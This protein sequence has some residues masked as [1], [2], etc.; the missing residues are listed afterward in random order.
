MKNLVRKLIARF[1]NRMLRS[2]KVWSMVD[3][4]RTILPR[5]SANP[6]LFIQ[7]FRTNTKNGN[8]VWYSFG[9]LS[10]WRYDTLFTKEPETI[11]WIESFS[12]R[13]VFWD[14]GANVGVYSIYA[15]AVRGCRVVAFE[16]SPTN[17]YVLTK[18]IQLNGLSERIVA[19]P[20]ALSDVTGMG[21]LNMHTLE[22]GGALSHF[23]ER[24][25]GISLD[26]H[27]HFPVEHRL[28]AAGF[29]ADALRA[30]MALE[31]PHHIK[32]D[33]DGI[34]DRIL[35]GAQGLL[36][37]K[38]LKSVLVEL[39]SGSALADKAAR[40]L[41]EVGFGLLDLP[42]GARASGANLLFR[43]TSEGTTPIGGVMLT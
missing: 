33:V 18:N 9:S 12:E 8:I 27:T 30:A 32:L 40:S 35:A 11:A 19:F 17:F 41:S 43:R 29:T 28:H 7:Q 37:D 21:Q 2:D 23:G 42:Q 34:E 36:G 13:D 22:P 14:I 24:V 20:F 5:V 26:A 3:P 6:E 38:R 15:A 16:P 31:F 39:D 1:L 25:E 4:Q 10:Q